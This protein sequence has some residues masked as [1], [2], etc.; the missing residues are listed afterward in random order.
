MI[1]M[2]VDP[3]KLGA[4]VTVNEAGVLL[5]VQRQPLVGG[6]SGKE[7]SLTEMN[8]IIRHQKP[9]LVTVEH[10]QAGPVMSKHASVSL[11][12]SLGRWEGLV[13][14]REIALQTVRPKAWQKIVGTERIGAKDIKSAC[15]ACALNLWPSVLGGLLKVKRNQG[16]ADAALIAEW[17]RRQWLGR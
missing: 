4:I 17:S 8:E 14:A 10:I 5:F 2:G 3:G 16:M 1:F 15:T 7:E 12:K 11:G 13:A 9:D 6:L